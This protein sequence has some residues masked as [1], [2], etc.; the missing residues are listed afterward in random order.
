MQNPEQLKSSEILTERSKESSSIDPR[1]T[2]ERVHELFAER[3]EMLSSIEQILSP[4]LREAIGI[5]LNNERERLDVLMQ[6]DLKQATFEQ[7]Q[8]EL[9]DVQYFRKGSLAHAAQ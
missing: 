5:K 6:M 3:R 1:V 2:A 8:A 4:R 7:Q 9:L